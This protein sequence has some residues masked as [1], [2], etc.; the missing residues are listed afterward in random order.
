MP[1]LQLVKDFAGLF[2]PEVCLCCGED[3]VAKEEYICATCM[4][5]LPR[6]NYHK[7]TDSPL[8][9]VFWGRVELN[10]VSAF[11]HY[12]KGGTVQGL[13]HEMKYNGKKKLGTELGRLYGVELKE[14]PL[15]N[16]ADYIVYIPLHPK[17]LKK[18][19]YNQSAFFAEGLSQGMGIPVLHDA[20]SRIKNTDTQTRK[21]RYER[22]ENVEGIFKVDKVEELSGKHVLLVDDVITTGSTIEACARELN[23]AQVASVSVAAIGSADTISSI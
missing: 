22:W 2:Y 3:L 20:L 5:S 17:K 11:C 6:T 8:A 23:K 4:F 19:G 13:V 21:S 18:R 16:R 12:Q 9:K 1:L 7:N 14:S 15:F 10:A